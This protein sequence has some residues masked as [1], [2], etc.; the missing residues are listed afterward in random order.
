MALHVAF[1]MYPVTDMARASAF[2]TDVLGLKKDGLDSEWWAEFDVDGT[3]FGIG[4]F[5]QC[6]TAGTATSFA[7]EVDD[8]AAFR[9][10]LKAQGV[11]SNEPFETPIC[12]I[13]G[14]LDP[15]GNTVILHQSKHT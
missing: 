12:W 4:N 14:V 3:T 15:D 1:I 8:M 10:D 13:S 6:G 9:S 5:P 2:Y 11:E 7:L